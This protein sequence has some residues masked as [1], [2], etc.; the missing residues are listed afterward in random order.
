MKRIELL[1]YIYGQTV[2]SVEETVEAFEYFVADLQAMSLLHDE[3]VTAMVRIGKRILEDKNLTE[4]E[5]V[6]KSGRF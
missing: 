5:K 6:I 1:E 4:K 2:C 3:E